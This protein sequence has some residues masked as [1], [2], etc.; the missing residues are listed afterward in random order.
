MVVGFKTLVEWNTRWVVHGAFW[1]QQRIL[2]NRCGQPW[3]APRCLRYGY[4]SSV[5]I[6]GNASTKGKAFFID[7]VYVKE[8]LI[9]SI[10]E[11]GN[12]RRMSHWRVHESYWR[13]TIEMASI[14]NDNLRVTTLIAI[15]L[16][17]CALETA[18]EVAILH[19]HE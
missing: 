12:D 1:R 5:Y 7:F 19:W 2:I 9:L 15:V 10:A 14:R 11:H 3:L 8:G 17:V 16:V 6:F 13:L 4:P 18:D